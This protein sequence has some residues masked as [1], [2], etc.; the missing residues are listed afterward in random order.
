VTTGRFTVGS[1]QI[2][3]KIKIRMEGKI[4]QKDEIKG[5]QIPCI[6]I[7]KLNMSSSNSSDNEEIKT[8]HLSQGLLRL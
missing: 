3:N 5:N 7:I 6:L 8:T 2:Y 4:I 1:I